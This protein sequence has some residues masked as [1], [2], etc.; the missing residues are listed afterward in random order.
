SKLL[1][2]PKAVINI[3]NWVSNPDMDLDFFQTRN[4]L[5]APFILSRI[6]C[7]QEIFLMESLL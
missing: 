4:T 5:I 1:D 6:E 3:A 7:M 2:Q